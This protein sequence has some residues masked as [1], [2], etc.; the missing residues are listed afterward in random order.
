MFLFSLCVCVYFSVLFWLLFCFY[1]SVC[2]VKR[3][4]HGVGWAGRIWEERREG[5]PWSNTLHEKTLFKR[6]K[7]I[8]SCWERYL[9]DHNLWPLHACTHK[10]VHTRTWLTHRPL[11]VK[12]DTKHTAY[13]PTVW[14]RMGTCRDR[15]RTSRREREEPEGRESELGPA[16]Q[17]RTQ[18]EATGTPRTTSATL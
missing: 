7:M 2:S 13:F 5:E 14:I 17:G 4:G 3:G 10:H 16:E 18:R 1:L 8:K 12:K 11:E 9:P 15:Q 6:K